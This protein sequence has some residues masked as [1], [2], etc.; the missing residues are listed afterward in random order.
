VT[1]LNLRRIAGIRST[2]VRIAA[3][4]VIAATAPV[5]INAP[6]AS[7][8]FAGVQSSSTMPG[9]SD[10]LAMIGNLLDRG[11]GI[12]AENVARALLA[13]VETA[14]GA[15]ALEVAEVL[16]LLTRAIRR[17]PRVKAEEKTQ[18]A[19]RAVAIKEKLLTPT[20]PALATSLLNLGIQRT[21][22][23]EPAAAKPLL[24]RAL[25]IREAAFG[26]DDLRVAGALES[27]AGTLMT[28]SDDAGAKVALERAQRI[29]ET[30]YGAAHPEAVRTL[31][32][33]AIFCQETGDY[34]GARERYE[35]ALT[36]AEGMP[37]SADLLTLHVLTGAGVI[38]SELG[39]DYAGSATLNERLL[40]M[41]ERSFGAT[42]P[43]LRTPL[44]NLAIDRRDLG[45]YAV[46]R[47]LAERS[48]AIGER[49]FG[50]K[51]PEVAGSL[52][53]LATILAAAGEY[54]EAM[55]LFERA[56][57]I[58]E[59]A[60]HPG[61]PELS[62]ATWFIRDLLPVS[63]YSA[64]DA[65]LFQRAVETRE[66]AGGL[67]DPLTTD[68]LSNLVAVLSSPED[69][70]RTRPLLERALMS[71]ERF[72]GP[73]HPE[74]AA[75]AT[76]LAYVL[77]QTG[78]EV[79]ARS[80]YE[81]A[82]GIW[83]KA[84][85]ADHPRV[86]LALCNLASVYVHDGKYD[87]AGS[88]LRRA[89]AIQVKDLGPEHPDTASTLMKLAEVNVRAGSSLEA[90]R[91]AARGEDIW[92]EHMRLT[93][94]AL[95]ERQ[96]LAYAASGGAALDVMLSIASTHPE[97]SA[98]TTIAWNDV[99]RA[100]G[101]VFDEMAARHQVASATDDQEIVALTRSLSAARERLAAA[102]VRGIRGDT[103]ERY[104]RMLDEARSEKD[105]AERDLAEKSA[106]FG[107]DQSR[108]TAGVPELAARL[109][110]ESVLVGFVRYRRYDVDQ[111]PANPSRAADPE[112]S[113]L[114]F[115]LRAGDNRPALVP[116]GS[117][118]RIESL[119]PQWRRQLDQEAMAPATGASRNEAA[120][121]RVAG[122]LRR[123]VWDPLPTYVSE[124]K[125]VFVVP[126]GALLLVSF[127]AL[128]TTGSR[129]L[130]E[131]GPFIQYLS[132]ERDLIPAQGS[133]PA[134]EGLLAMGGP[135][136]DTI[137]S[138]GIA[139]KASFRGARAACG[140]FQSMR[141]EPLPASLKE[142]DEVASLWDRAE[143][144]Q[145][146][147]VHLASAKPSGPSVL[148]LTGAAASESAFKADAA[149]RRV[150]HLATHG[151]FL[152]E[153]CLS[154][155]ESS[156][157][158]APDASAKVARENPLLLSGLVL[159]GANQRAVA[160]SDQDDGVLTAEEVAAL[161]LSGVEWAVLSGCDTGR[162]ELRAGEGIFGLRRAFQV[163]GAKTVIMSLWSV[164]DRA[165]RQWMVALYT[166]RLIKGLSTAEAV[167]EA[168]L[169]LLRHRR[170]AGLSTHP[171]YWAGFVASGDP[172]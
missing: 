44:E 92:R 108:S 161:D 94:R 146:Q 2:G 165:T 22:Q 107:D 13:R 52:H 127:A 75:A 78:D 34:A 3:S 81:R 95:P 89:L 69:Y 47:A 24:E 83:E 153:R 149:G 93:A 51:D 10:A 129:Y 25:T 103:P 82:L 101:T 41:S 49:V 143:G 120:Y 56:T 166:G 137:G 172:R 102:V 126:D 40:A 57:Q 59:E 121:R 167:H 134:G 65:I 169:G 99:I 111:A 138:G 67:A 164:E 35:R 73:D 68:S 171:F 113:Y 158:S 150:L 14:Q 54:G 123:Q 90:F 141:F 71:R 170:A 115:V 61:D 38:L 139:S 130:V 37:A 15:D 39:G 124:A 60:L 70:R 135:A 76:N 105:R 110:P 45:D 109:P 154:A 157:T 53:T 136:F 112:P 18:F 128:P 21:L 84:L 98:M 80:L 77:F 58:N 11:R 117:A 162:G 26:P 33:L 28:L 145:A 88:L 20:D 62:R 32:N 142:V 30:V 160:A 87:E 29:R 122:D 36:L 1:N 79:A 16:D 148:R 147:G 4:V 5:G 159:A 66:E 85:G 163:A 17:S 48:L 151:F 9:F 63:G 12:E 42:D 64:D 168:S 46:A 96:A 8:R 116:L 118:S 86:A 104:R 19:E 125:G 114:A 72:L 144:T 91:T 119:I 7:A 55:R 152:G 97:D 131:A 155:P 27:L 132:A 133:R 106:R 50:P 156:M 74:V 31:V 23:G 6:M 43:R 100:R 140:N